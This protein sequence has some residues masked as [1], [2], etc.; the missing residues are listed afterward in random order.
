MF[1]QNFSP[2]FYGIGFSPKQHYKN[3]AFL[4]H[5]Q[6]K[7]PDCCSYVVCNNFFGVG[8]QS[9]YVITDRPYGGIYIKWKQLWFSP[10][11]IKAIT[12]SLTQ[13]VRI[14]SWWIL[15]REKTSFFWMEDIRTRSNMHEFCFSVN[16]VDFDRIE[17]FSMTHFCVCWTEPRG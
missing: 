11:L 1:V 16:K 5:I 9:A 6:Q 12:F 3:E 4:H 13:C 15:Q 14:P 8:V 17:F 2:F 7:K 10:L